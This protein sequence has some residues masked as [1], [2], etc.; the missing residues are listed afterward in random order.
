MC[1]VA[2]EHRL[3]LRKPPARHHILGLF[4][5]TGVCACVCGVLGA[6]VRVVVVVWVVLGGVCVCVGGCCVVWVCVCVCV[7]GACVLKQR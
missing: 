1:G 6:C 5:G 4:R 2:G 3:G 7:L